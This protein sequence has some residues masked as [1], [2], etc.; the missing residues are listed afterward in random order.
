LKDI[1]SFIKH[2]QFKAILIW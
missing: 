1:Q 2:A